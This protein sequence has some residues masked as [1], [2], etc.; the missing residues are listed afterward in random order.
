MSSNLLRDSVFENHSY[1]RQNATCPLASEFSP[2][3]RSREL[4]ILTVINAV[5]SLSGVSLN[6]MALFIL[7]TNSS[8]V[9]VPANIIL[10]SLVVN[11]LVSSTIFLPYHAYLFRQ[12]CVTLVEIRT[13]RTAAAFCS[14]W[15]VLNCLAITADRLLA[16]LYPLRYNSLIVALKARV[17][18]VLAVGITTVFTLSLFA[19]SY[20]WKHFLKLILEYMA[21]VILLLPVFLYWK[22]YRSARKQIKEITI[23]SRTNAEELKMSLKS[24]AN[25]ARVVVLLA[26]SFVPLLAYGILV[27]DSD[28]TL[29]DTF[30]ILTKAASFCFWNSC[31]NPLV[32]LYFP[33]NFE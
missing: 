16:I 27:E 13:Y 21:V 12:S 3:L 33:E 26:A 29:A 22:I 2:N 23:G 18:V 17:L 19:A 32:Y 25:S 24:A 10:C 8:L 28:R 1:A 5:Q 15:S 9:E 4:T 20:L 31:A 11:D 30:R 7:V 6:S 14:T